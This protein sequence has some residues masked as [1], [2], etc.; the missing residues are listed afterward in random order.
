MTRELIEAGAG[1][2]KTYSIVSRYIQALGYD[3]KGQKIKGVESFSPSEIICLTFTELAASQMLDRILERLSSLDLDHL[4]AEVIETSRISTFHGYCYKSLGPYLSDLG[5]ENTE[6]LP[7]SLTRAQKRQWL[8]NQ[9]QRHPS[10]IFENIKLN[11]LLELA[12]ETWF[13]DHSANPAVLE[14]KLQSYQS[15]YLKFLSTLKQDLVQTTTDL[16]HDLSENA[17]SWPAQA[18]NKLASKNPDLSE[19]T[20]RS[21]GKPSLKEAAPALLERVSQLRDFHQS[22]FQKLLTEESIQREVST[23]HEIFSYLKSIRINPPKLLDFA[24]L[25]YE[26]LELLRHP[27]EKVR[28]Q[29]PKLFIVDEFQDTSPEQFEIIQKLSSD[30]TQWYFVGDPKQSIYSFRKADIRLYS[31]LKK[32]LKLVSL[33]NNWRSHPKLL[34]IFN[35]IQE[36]LFDRSSEFDPSPQN[37]K[38]GIPDPSSLHPNAPNL[39]VHE[40]P[41][42]VDLFDFFKNS[43]LQ[44]CQEKPGRSHAALFRSWNKLYHYAQSLQK[45]KIPFRIIGSENFLNH[46]LSELFILYLFWADKPED[47]EARLAL[48]RWTHGDFIEELETD[49]LSA[50]KLNTPSGHLLDFTQ[51]IQPRRWLN[52]A[53]WAA[54]M[55]RKL[56]ALEKLHLHYSLSPSDLAFYIKDSLSHDDTSL[57]SVQSRNHTSAETVNLMTIHASKGLEF[58]CVYLVE[59]LETLRTSFDMSIGDEDESVA[60]LEFFNATSRNYQPSLFYKTKSYE[61]SLNEHSESKRVFYVAFTRSKE[62]LDVLINSPSKSATR[63]IKTAMPILGLASGKKAPWNLILKESSGRWNQKDVEWLQS[64]AKPQQSGE[65]ESQW[66]LPE[67]LQASNLSTHF[68]GGV[69]DFL[70]DQE[71]SSPETSR[72]QKVSTAELGTKL[73]EALSVWDGDLNKIS[74]L[75]H[76]NL[77]P[78]LQPIFNNL[79]SLQELKPFWTALQSDESR[80]LRELPLLISHKQEY[81]LSGVADAIALIDNEIWVLDWKSSGSLSSFRTEERIQ[82]IREQLKLYASAFIQQDLRIKLVAVG[83]DVNRHQ[84]KVLIN[85]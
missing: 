54:A 68:R 23:Q 45:E 6:L 5:Y 76:I 84:V 3:E 28:L 22:G 71:V 10:L 50:K 2:G 63:D 42:K 24:A 80:I 73:H 60:K 31:K 14:E 72:I 67:M 43:Y 15:H 7:T 41:R 49:F 78:E 32:E 47:L 77:H 37:L 48:K 81:T 53:E 34:E 8:L 38:S 65:A 59:P 62:C 64:E 20:F 51:L 9:F 85:E 40:A 21:N 36:K 39:R 29:K 33:E 27:S 25:E 35:T 18:I 55:E 61:K 30:E 46:H 57:D 16:G 12:Q 44:R 58:D 83:I 56:I 79:L 82:K 66:L 70:K 75:P 19:V 74:K 69:S 52:G 1:C 4:K 17:K 13:S 26:F 11:S